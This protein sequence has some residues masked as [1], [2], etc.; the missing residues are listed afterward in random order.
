MK[1]EEVETIPTR[2]YGNN[3]LSPKA[4]AISKALQNV[5]IVST[6]EEIPNEK[7][8]QNDDDIITTNLLKRGWATYPGNSKFNLNDECITKL[9]QLYEKGKGKNNKSDRVMVERAYDI[10]INE[11]ISINWT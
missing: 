7:S 6:E 2:N 1:E 10:L 9:I 5:G 8:D 4:T 3:R 11:I